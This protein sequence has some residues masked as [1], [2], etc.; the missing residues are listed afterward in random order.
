MRNDIEAL[1]QFMFG[2]GNPSRNYK[3]QIRKSI[4]LKREIFAKLRDFREALKGIDEN[5]KPKLSEKDRKVLTDNFF[6]IRRVKNRE[7]GNKEPMIV[8]VVLPAQSTVFMGISRIGKTYLLETVR[9]YYRYVV[10]RLNLMILSNNN[11]REERRRYWFRK[12]SDALS[13]YGY[14]YMT[15]T[16]V[17]TAAEDRE[18]DLLLKKLNERKLIMID[19]IFY[20]ANW[21]FSDSTITAS[22]IHAGYKTFYDF[23]S[24]AVHPRVYIDEY[25]IEKVLPGVIVIA[26]TNNTPSKYID[27]DIVKNRIY[28]IFQNKIILD[29]KK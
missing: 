1:K 3:P 2:G 21:K 13:T 22:D 5:G 16:N 23:L 12:I 20:E 25:G 11:S 19:E 15:E 8:K 7:T 10:D 27:K 4:I 26:T 6:V 18:I 9:D 24:K 29:G 14:W 28:E 17:K